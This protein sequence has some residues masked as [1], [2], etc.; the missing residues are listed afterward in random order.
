MSGLPAGRPVALLAQQR[1]LR[2][3]T[4]SNCTTIDISAQDNSISKSAHIMATG[5]SAESENIMLARGILDHWI[6]VE[7][8]GRLQELALLGG[9]QFSPGEGQSSPG[10]G[11][12]LPG[13]GQSPLDEG[14]A[15]QAAS[16]PEGPAAQ[17]VSKS[18][19]RAFRATIRPRYD[20]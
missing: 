16:K 19:K 6:G 9:V 1:G 5:S 14:P 15:A 18:S 13:E 7:A 3:S 11:Q 17:S 8:E 12:S 4:S 20:Y 10:K 2:V